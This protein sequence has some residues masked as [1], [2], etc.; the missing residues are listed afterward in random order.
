MR[1]RLRKRCSECRRPL[2]QPRKAS[3]SIVCHKC[4]PEHTSRTERRMAKMRL[5]AT[6]YGAG[7]KVQELLSKD[8]DV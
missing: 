4:R 2:A 6:I 7:N 8:S 5:F 3:K 1:N